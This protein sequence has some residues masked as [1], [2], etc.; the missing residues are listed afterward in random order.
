MRQETRAELREAVKAVEQEQEG[1][2]DLIARANGVLFLL[3]EE[4]E[5]AGSLRAVRPLEDIEADDEHVREWLRRLRRRERLCS[6]KISQLM[7]AEHEL[8]WK[9]A[10]AKN[11]AKCIP[12]QRPTPAQ[13]NVPFNPD[14]DEKK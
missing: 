10:R 14:E 12:A 9:M 8:A 5:N 1:I 13:G 3:Q 4:A 11:A 2:R 7:E 6:R